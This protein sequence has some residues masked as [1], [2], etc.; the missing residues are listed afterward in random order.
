[1]LVSDIRFSLDHGRVNSADEIPQCHTMSESDKFI[2]D[3]ARRNNLS[4][5]NITLL[6]AQTMTY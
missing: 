6:T 5:A 4:A 1:M 3:I 2:N